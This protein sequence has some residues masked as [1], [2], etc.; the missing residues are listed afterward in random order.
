MKKFKPY[1][2]KA[3]VAIQLSIEEANALFTQS[4]IES[5][6]SCFT[7]K[8][9]GAQ[10]I[11]SASAIAISFVYENNRP[12]F[13]T[14]YGKHTLCNMKDGCGYS[15]EGVVSINGK[16]YR[17]FTSDKLFQLPNGKY[18]NAAIIYVCLDQSRK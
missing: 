2:K 7:M 9:I 13:A 10:T 12:E 4:E 3:D 11:H 15:I 17:G 16:R 18:I 6:K 14:I 1:T 5:G 8:T